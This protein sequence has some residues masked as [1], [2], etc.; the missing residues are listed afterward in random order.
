M[1]GVDTLM[2]YLLAV[3]TLSYE[4][5]YFHRSQSLLTH[6]LLVSMASFSPAD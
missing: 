2:T 5:Y 4:C 6:F 3:E 1:V